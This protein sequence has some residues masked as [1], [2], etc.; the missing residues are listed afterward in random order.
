MG[1]I[2]FTQEPKGVDAGSDYDTLYTYDV[3]GEVTK[4][5][6]PLLSGQQNRSHPQEIA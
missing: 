1:W 3:M 5:E 6:F 4:K 2:I